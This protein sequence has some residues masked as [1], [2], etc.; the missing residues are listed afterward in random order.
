MRNFSHSLSERE[1]TAHRWS[2]LVWFHPSEAYFPSSVPFFLQHITPRYSEVIK[3]CICI[4]CYINVNNVHMQYPTHKHQDVIRWKCQ[5]IC[6]NPFKH[7]FLFCS[8]TGERHGELQQGLRGLGLNL[9]SG[10]PSQDFYLLAPHNFGMAH[11][12][13]KILQ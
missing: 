10:R 5:D 6:S 13:Y 1:V 3:M 2:P 11:H 4:L 12:S 9:P 8:S 7:Y